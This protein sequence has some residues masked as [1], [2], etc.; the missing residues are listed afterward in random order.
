MMV[1]PFSAFHT[2][3]C[4]FVAG[5]RQRLMKRLAAYEP[6]N[7]M[8]DAVLY[9]GLV[10]L[11]YALVALSA[12]CKHTAQDAVQFVRY[13]CAEGK[14]N[15]VASLLLTTSEGAVKRLFSRHDANEIHFRPSS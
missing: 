5:Y 10:A 6:F 1:G 2:R 11:T 8:A 7:K 4:L 3:A 14:Y 9:G 15:P 13:D 12:N